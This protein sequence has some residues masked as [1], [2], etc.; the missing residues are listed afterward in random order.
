MIVNT[1]IIDA[2]FGSY[3]TEK[4]Y[5]EDTG[6]LCDSCLA[7]PTFKPEMLSFFGPPIWS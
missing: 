1:V 5:M 7:L 4:C 3:E 6:E 2:I